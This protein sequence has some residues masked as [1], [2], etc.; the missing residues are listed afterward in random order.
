[1][2]N[3]QL[4]IGVCSREGT[5]DHQRE[6]YSLMVSLADPEL[7]DIGISK[8][9]RLQNHLLLYFHDLDDIEI[10]APKYA[11]CKKPQKCHVEAIFQAFQKL[12]GDPTTNEIGALIHCEAG[13]SRSTAAAIL[14]LTSLNIHPETAFEEIIRMNPLGLPNRRMLRIGCEI[15]GKGHGMLKL[16]EIQRRELFEQYKQVDPIQILETSLAERNQTLLS[17]ERL[18]K[19]LEALVKGCKDAALEKTL[20]RWR[21]K[22][23]MAAQKKLDPIHQP[24]RESLRSIREPQSEPA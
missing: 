4:L 18:L 23:Q 16:A 14:G 17:I 11:G 9:P 21:T 22:T 7:G 10:R 2:S 19:E 20:E 3:R 24:K 13:I 15:L 5:K 12:E 6:E 1:M 8:P